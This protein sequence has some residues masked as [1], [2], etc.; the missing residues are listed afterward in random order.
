MDD[1]KSKDQVE[2][3]VLA[4]LS[5]HKGKERSISRWELVERIFGRD[6]AADRSNNNPFDRRIRDVIARN[7]VKYL[8][9]SSSGQSG[10]WLAADINDVETIAQE[11]VERSR[12]ME[13]LARKI[14]RN[15]AEQFGPQMPLL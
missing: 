8:I 6:A 13:E 1:S 2:S 5:F 15:G 10:Y 12:Q 3:E 11:F 14:R 7:R 9:V 4:I